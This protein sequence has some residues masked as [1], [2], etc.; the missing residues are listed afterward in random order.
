MH[1][2][3]QTLRQIVHSSIGG[4]RVR[5]VLSNAYG[6]TPLTIGAAHVALRDKDSSI[7]VES[8]R[9]L[10]FSG[11][12]T[13]TIPANAVIYSDPVNLTIPEMADMAIDLCPATP[14]RRRR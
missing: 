5:V 6:T 9:P 8:D 7:K 1:F 3:N 11:K 12:S 13:I 10:T 14:I 4:S 2:K